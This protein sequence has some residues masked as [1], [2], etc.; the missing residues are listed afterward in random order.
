MAASQ[1]Q[2]PGFPFPEKKADTGRGACLV[3]QGRGV[4]CGLGE[5]PEL[6]IKD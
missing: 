4:S 6:S 2:T 5:E 3:G 1:R